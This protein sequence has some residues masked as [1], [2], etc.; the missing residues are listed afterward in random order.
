M[1][2]VLVKVILHFLNRLIEFSPTSNSEMLIKKCSMQTL[3]ISI[4]LRPADLRCPMLNFF[5][6]KKQFKRMLIRTT[7][8]FTAI[9][10]QHCF[11]LNIVLFKERQHIIVKRLNRSHRN[12]GRVHPSPC[13]PAVAIDH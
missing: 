6:L 10:R 11:N 2:K 13:I 9:V 8:V 3:N 5:K 7:A 12:L 4:T 1:L